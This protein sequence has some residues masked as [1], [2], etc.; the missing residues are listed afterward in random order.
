LPPLL[1]AA[2][3]LPRTLNAYDHSHTCLGCLV[4]FVLSHVPRQPAPSAF[5]SHFASSGVVAAMS[6]DSALA[7]ALAQFQAAR[8]AQDIDAVV[9]V[10]LAH[11]A[12]MLRSGQAA[13]AIAATL[14]EWKLTRRGVLI[15]SLPPPAAHALLDAVAATLRNNER[16]DEAV[17][18]C[19]LVTV[20]GA[21]AV[22]D[23]W[24]YALLQAGLAEELVAA[25]RRH[26]NAFMV[27]AMACAAL[28]GAA[29]RLQTKGASEALDSTPRLRRPRLDEAVRAWRARKP[30]HRSPTSCN[31]PR[32]CRRRS[33]G[34]ARA[35][36]V[37]GG[38]Y[39]Q[40]HTCV[41]RESAR[42]FTQHCAC[43]VRVNGKLAHAWRG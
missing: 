4:T 39:K 14:S 27:Q 5:R 29:R 18:A 7:A 24:P 33:S 30:P 2:L 26:R 11:K 15:P 13:H 38:K 32:A 35:G 17:N 40:Q 23:A 41:S 22:E 25:M 34:T 42:T 28:A 36:S 1:L 21:C 10:I 8:A 37:S 19:M 16:L 12:V 31:P 3:V 9:R 20:V 43:G 6:A